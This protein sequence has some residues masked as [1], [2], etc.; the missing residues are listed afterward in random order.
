MFYLERA[1]FAQEYMMVQSKH[2]LYY[3][4]PYCTQMRGERVAKNVPVFFCLPGVL[5]KATAVCTVKLR[6]NICC[7]YVGDTLHNLRNYFL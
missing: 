2:T 5:L 6:C 7:P 4:E 3:I 1:L